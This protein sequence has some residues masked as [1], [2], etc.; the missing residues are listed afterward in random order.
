[1]KLEY[2]ENS[3]KY[4]TVKEVLKSHFH[5]SER[6]LLKLKRHGQIFLNNQPT[7]VNTPIHK[8]D[9]ITIE[10]SFDEKSENIIPKQIPLDIIFEDNAL[11]I[12]NKP[13][14]FTGSSFCLSF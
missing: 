14:R 3:N 11:L 12:I 4:K 8:N 13:A 1:M 5:I 7:F 2:I 6:L 10:L 9:V